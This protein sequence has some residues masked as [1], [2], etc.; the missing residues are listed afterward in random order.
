MKTGR[1]PLFF[2]LAI[3]LFTQAGCA[4]TAPAAQGAGD[5]RSGTIALSGAFALYPM[6]VQW[7][8]EYTTLYPKVRIDVTAGGA[9]KGM[10]DTLGGVVD[11]GMVS[12]DV[13]P[14]EIS[15][16]AF[17]IAV[18]KDAVFAVVSEQN[19][20]LADL[21]Y[22]GVTP[23]TLSKVWIEGASTTWGDLVGRADVTDEVHV[24]TRSDAAGAADVWALFLGGKAQEDLQGVGVSGDPGITEAVAKDPLGIGYNNLGY[25]FDASTGKPVTGVAVVPIDRNGNGKADPEEVFETKAAAVQAVADGAYPSPPARVLYLVTKGKPSGATADFLKW[26]LTD[27]QKYVTDAGYIPLPADQLS[28]EL[29]KLQ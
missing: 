14:E 2:L 16:G 20:V 4:P 29:Q 28:G 24:Y 5:P 18:T 25:A 27:G 21:V 19:P 23:Q 26:I 6:A 13:K 11:I 1:S 10:A 9:G 3:L 8:D 7:S 22:K 17:P 15:Q 12:R